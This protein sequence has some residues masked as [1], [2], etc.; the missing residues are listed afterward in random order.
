[1]YFHCGFVLNLSWV[2]IG[3]LHNEPVLS[4]NINHHLRPF[5]FIAP[6]TSLWPIL[7]N[8]VQKLKNEF[9]TEYRKVSSSNKESKKREKSSSIIRQVR[10]SSWLRDEAQI[11]NKG[12]KKSVITSETTNLFM[13]LGRYFL[14]LLWDNLLWYIDR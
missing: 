11:L 14:T 2:L 12:G 8:I 10:V 3:N 7:L 9:Y 4:L 1:M 13:S 6:V 5:C